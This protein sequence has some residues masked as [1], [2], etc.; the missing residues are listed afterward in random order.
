MTDADQVVVVG[1]DT[2]RDTHYAVVV[3][4]RGGELGG[5]EFP[6]TGPGYA[7]LVAWAGSFG[8]LVKAGVEGT[9]SYG[10]GLTAHLHSTGLAV[11]EVTSPDRQQRRHR[12]KTDQLDAL[13]AAR[14]AASG[15]ASVVPKLRDGLVEMIQIL[16]TERRLVVKQNTETMNALRGGIVTAPEPVRAR[17]GK[18]TGVTLAKACVNLPVLDSDD[19]LAKTTIQ[20]LQRRGQAWL[21]GRA[22]A[23]TLLAE[24]EVLVAEVNPALLAEYGVG[25]DSAAALLVCVGGNPDRVTSEAAL[26]RMTGVAPI[27]ASSGLSNKYRLSRGGDRQ[28]NAA[29]HRI[30]VVRLKSHPETRAY[31]DRTIARGKTRKDAHRLLKRYLARRLY[32]ILLNRPE[33]HQIAG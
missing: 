14:A 13:H 1:V 3:D 28:A 23:K 22:Q 20:M 33:T 31:R 19:D 2:H 26:A 8:Q 18:A 15:Q 30:I 12:G 5:A 25:P 16:H 24:L 7:D 11:V 29:L 6:A 17:L 32:P 10:A 27:P 21:E 4:E 9:G